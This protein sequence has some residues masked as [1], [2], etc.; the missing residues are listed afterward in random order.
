MKESASKYLQFVRLRA[1]FRVSFDLIKRMVAAKSLFYSFV[2]IH[3]DS[4]SRLAA[5]SVQ[6]NVSQAKKE[7]RQI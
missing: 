4:A 1:F 3:C 7:V 5:F 6:N 2:V